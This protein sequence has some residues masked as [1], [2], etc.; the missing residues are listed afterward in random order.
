MS[1]TICH[2]FADCPVCQQPVRWMHGKVPTDLNWNSKLFCMSDRIL[3]YFFHTLNS[4]IGKNI[5]QMFQYRQLFIHFIRVFFSFQYS[6]YWQKASSKIVMNLHF[7]DKRLLLSDFISDFFVHFLQLM[8]QDFQLFI[9]CPDFF[10]IVINFWY[11]NCHCLQ[12]S[13]TIRLLQTIFLKHPDGT[14]RKIKHITVFAQSA[15]TFRFRFPTHC[16]P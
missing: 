12:I 13:C 14:I 4:R 9:V 2:T 7:H 3:I 16:F 11:I 10:T 6:S 15:K 5:N 1:G 8:I